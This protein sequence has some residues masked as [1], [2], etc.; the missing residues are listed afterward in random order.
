M[1]SP[2]TVADPLTGLPNR[3]GS[4]ALIASK[5]REPVRPLAVALIDVDR[6][7][8]VNARYF[9]PAGDRILAE[10]ARLIVGALRSGDCL[11]RIGGDRFVLIAPE[12]GVEDAITLAECIRSIAQRHQFAYEHHTVVLSVSVGCVV[13]PQGVVMD[14]DQLKMLAAAALSHAKQ[15]GGNRALVVSAHDPL[16]GLPVTKDDF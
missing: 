7:K 2:S 4:E 12:T 14:I 13:V 10:L 9:I 11:G 6:F 16:V 8:E 5:L 15:Q 1:H 3:Q